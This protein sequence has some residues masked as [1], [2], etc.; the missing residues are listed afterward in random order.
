MSLTVIVY[1]F[2]IAGIVIGGALLKGAVG[3]RWTAI[4]AV[5]WTLWHIFAPWLMLLQFFTI[6]IAY[7]IGNAIVGEEK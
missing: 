2:V 1:Q 5:V 3:L 6:A 7:A 4:G